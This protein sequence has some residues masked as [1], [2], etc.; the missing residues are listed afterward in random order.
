MDLSE[1]LAI[2]G[3]S[4][5][6]KV[7]SQTKNG[8][9]VESLIDG[10]KTPVFA[11]DRS[12]S[13]EDISV[14]TEKEDLLLKEVFKKIHEK[15]NGGKALDHKSDK[16]ELIKY[17]GEVLPDYDKDRVYF[18]DIKKII[19]WYN[20]LHDKKMLDFKEE[21]KKEKSSDKES[22]ASKDLPEG[23]AKP[24]QE[25]TG[26]PKTTVNPKAKAPKSQSAKGVNV[27]S[28]GIGVKQK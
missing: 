6:Y 4:G 14:F 10:K 16:A 1:I 13:L 8:L 24:I 15:E 28:K 26:K 21:D 18:S 17:F 20:L 25:G 12:S 2:S 23:P 27:K 19:Y 3:K 9:I 7:V 11:S 5:L 22:A